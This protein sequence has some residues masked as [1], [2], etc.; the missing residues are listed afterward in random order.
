MVLR[1]AHR[2]AHLC[3]ALFASLY[4]RALGVAGS[5]QRGINNQR[6]SISLI[7]ASK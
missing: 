4:F 2:L 6:I 5:G 1:A 7:S 3:C